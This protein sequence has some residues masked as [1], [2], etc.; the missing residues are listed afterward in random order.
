[1]RAVRQ[2]GP[3]PAERVVAVP[4]ALATLRLTLPAGALLRDALADALAARGLDGAALRF[5][6]GALGPFG[7]VTPALSPDPFHSAF[8]SAPVR[9]AGPARIEGGAVTVGAKDGGPFLH[10][11]ALWRDAEGRPAAGHLL[12]DETRL[13]AETV[14]VG[15]GFTGARFEARP[16]PETGFALFAPVPTEPPARPDALALR[17]RPNQD[18][19]L[20]LEEVCAAQ[21]WRR[22]RLFGGVGSVIGARFS[23]GAGDTDAF[24]T[25]MFLTRAE[26]DPDGASHVAATL[27]DLDGAIGSGRLIRGDNPILM[28]L[29]GVLAPA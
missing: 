1:M 8:Y 5:E 15:V 23:G 18:L 14:L 2:P 17:L 27:V 10:A 22:A 6:T 26:I 16:D 3:A 29:E 9:P 28:T 25:E 11:H 4:V 7:Y 20:A 21:G 19:I 24:A 13:A 12:P